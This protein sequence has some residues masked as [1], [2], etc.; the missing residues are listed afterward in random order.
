MFDKHRWAVGVV[1]EA[2]IPIQSPQG[3]AITDLL[4][5]SAKRAQRLA[6]SSGP[7]GALDDLDFVCMAARALPVEAGASDRIEDALNLPHGTGEGLRLLQD[8]AAAAIRY[9]QDEGRDL[10]APRPERMREPW[11]APAR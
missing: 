7:R 8:V 3:K 9:Y 11:K 6:K 4:V 5:V 2:G 10:G 1:R